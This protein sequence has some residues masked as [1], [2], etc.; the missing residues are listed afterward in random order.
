MKI[1]VLFLAT[2]P[3]FAQFPRP[4]GGG[5]GGGGGGAPTGAAGGDLGGTYPNPAVAKINGITVT[6]TPSA[7]QVPTATGTTAATWQTPAAGALPAGSAGCVQLYGT[8][9]AFAC[10]GLQFTATALSDPST[11]TVTPISVGTDTCTYEVTAFN[12]IGYTNSVS[13]TTAT[14]VA[15][16]PNNNVA[17]ASVSGSIS[18]GIWRI[19]GGANL[20]RIDNGSFLCG[21]TLHDTNL[22]GDEYLPSPG[23]ETTGVSS[24][25]RVVGTGLGIGSENEGVVFDPNN[26][27]S[28]TLYIGSVAGSAVDPSPSTFIGRLVITDNAEN[29]DAGIV[30]RAYGGQFNANPY[31]IW[32][33][34]RG[35]IASPL[36]VQS[37]DSIGGIVNLTFD[38]VSFHEQQVV[39]VIVTGSVSGGVVPQTAEWSIP[40]QATGYNS[41]DGSTG[42]T[43]SA[44]TSF[45]NGLCVAGT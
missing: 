30:L 8:S 29:G 4:G 5:G 24:A 20:G 39:N 16:N 34:S 27:A 41:S 17:T 44:C 3:L 42:V 23:V 14:C 13:G 6:G 15:A 1:A 28:D 37:G 7:G 43:V 45:K 25:S 2:L 32:I 26:F 22:M 36:P 12:L 9:T 35:T 33:N 11:P 19:A 21:Q 40:I 10:A 18:C 31:M 38:G